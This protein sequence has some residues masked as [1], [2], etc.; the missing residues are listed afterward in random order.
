MLISQTVTDYISERLTEAGFSPCKIYEA[1]LGL[2]TN[3]AMS[4]EYPALITVNKVSLNQYSKAASDLCRA[5]VSLNVQCFG[6]KKGFYDA[7]A[8]QEMTETAL[9]EILFNSEMIISKLSCSQI[10]K[11][12]KYGRLEQDFDTILIT[13]IEQEE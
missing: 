5:E 1:D 11:N 7:D 8:L 2:K 6:S 9:S 3:G 4:A 12:I 10:K 13:S